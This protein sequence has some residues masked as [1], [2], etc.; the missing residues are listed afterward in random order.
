LESGVAVTTALREL[1]RR[2][3]VFQ[4][5]AFRVPDRE[6]DRAAQFRPPSPP[7]KLPERN[8]AC[9]SKSPQLPFQRRSTA[10]IACSR[11]RLEEDRATF[12]EARSAWTDHLMRRDNRT[13]AQLRSRLR[14]TRHGSRQLSKF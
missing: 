8:K 13:P 14:P 6:A 1:A 12:Q 9:L 4:R 3:C 5:P 10:A 7:S 2:F 11:P